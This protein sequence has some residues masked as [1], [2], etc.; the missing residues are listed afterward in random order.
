MQLFLLPCGVATDKV[1]PQRGPCGGHC[2]VSRFAA[3][4]YSSGGGGGSCWVEE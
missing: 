3:V 1:K 4:V 2:G